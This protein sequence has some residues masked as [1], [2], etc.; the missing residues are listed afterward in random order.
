MYRVKN[1]KRSINSANEITAAL[2]ELAK[3]K[4]FE[5]ITITELQQYS[6]VSR[7]TFYR[8]FDNLDDVITYCIESELSH[9]LQYC[10]ND[11][12]GPI[13]FLVKGFIFYFKSFPTLIDVDRIN[14]LIKYFGIFVEH[15][16]KSKTSEDK[17][18]CDLS[19]YMVYGSVFS[20]V[21]IWY[22]RGQIESEESL[23]ASI[24][25][26]LAKINKIINE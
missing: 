3:N 16:N 8:I 15:Y 22:K 23:I 13:E 7:S 14:S 10:N 19:Y 4:P 17:F 9:Y 5:D 6:K 11:E 20:A 1:D 21:L 2:I 26:N 24:K 12:H 18:N 25:S